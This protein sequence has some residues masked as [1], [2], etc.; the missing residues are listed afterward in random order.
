MTVTT[1]DVV[2]AIATDPDFIALARFDCSLAKFV[3]RYPDGAPSNTM[4]AK[5]LCTSEDDVER[6]YQE[7]MNFLKCAFLGKSE[8]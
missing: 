6:I 5:A 2:Q 4:I 3:D 7:S 8:V 1:E